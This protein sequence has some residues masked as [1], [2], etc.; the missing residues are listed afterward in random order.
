[1][2]REYKNALVNF[3]IFYFGQGLQVGV[4]DLRLYSRKDGLRF[5]KESA[6]EVGEVIVWI[7]SFAGCFFHEVLREVGGTVCVDVFSHPVEEG[8]VVCVVECGAH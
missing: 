2:L 7:C 1:M 4:L 3:D 8:C 5:A 6:F